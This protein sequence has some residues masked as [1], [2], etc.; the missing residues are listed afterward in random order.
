MLVNVTSKNY[1]NIRRNITKSNHC[2]E[3]LDLKFNKTPNAKLNGVPT[4]F[5]VEVGIITIQSKVYTSKQLCIKIFQTQYIS[6]ELSNSFPMRLGIILSRLL[7]QGY[8]T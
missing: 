4:L 3:Q 8:E 6:K 2:N 5:S 7:F 1:P